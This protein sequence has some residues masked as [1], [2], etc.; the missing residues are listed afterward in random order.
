MILQDSPDQSTELALSISKALTSSKKDTLIGLFSDKLSK[1][2]A[3][4]LL[5][6]MEQGKTIAFDIIEMH[7][8]VKVPR[9]EV[10][11]NFTSNE[12]HVIL[13]DNTHKYSAHDFKVV[14]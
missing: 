13:K 6:A 3:K 14:E 9:Y 1:V 2:K 11:I 4:Q 12:V 7:G 8:K 5:A 10:V